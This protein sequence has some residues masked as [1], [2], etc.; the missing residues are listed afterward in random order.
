MSKLN[1]YLKHRLHLF[2]W[3]SS[4]SISLLSSSMGAHHIGW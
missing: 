2:P 1:E 4:D 3:S